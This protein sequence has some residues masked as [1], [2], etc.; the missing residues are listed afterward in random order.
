MRILLVSPIFPPQPTVGAARTHSFAREWTRLGHEV[1]VLTTAKQS[2]QQG[3]PLPGEGFEVVAIDYPVPAPLARLR[4]RTREEPATA[5]RGR[6][7]NT[8]ARLRRFS[9][10]YGALRAPDLTHHWVRPAIDWA[11]R[12]GPWEVVCSSF[13]PY[14]AHLAALE[15][16]DVTKAWIAD[17]RDPWTDHWLARGLY[18]I[19]RI[20]RRWEQQVLDGAD[21]LVTTTTEFANRLAARTTTPVEVVYNGFDEEA[22]STLDPTPAWPHD[23]GVTRLVYTGSLYPGWHD[24]DPLF[25]ALYHAG[26]TKVR[27]IVAG[28]AAPSWRA[29]AER[30]GCAHLLEHHGTVV[31][32]EARRMQRDASALL[33]L[34]G[35]KRHGGALPAKVLEYLPSP[36]P[37]LAF[38]A[39]EAS[40]TQRL[41]SDTG[42]GITTPGD[43]PS[44]FLLLEQLLAGTLSL[45]TRD[46]SRIAFYG[47]RHQAR[48]LAAIVE[49]NLAS[50]RRLVS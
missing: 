4:Q 32:D 31:P 3:W 1:T 49:R 12:H 50:R 6:L 29:A 44:I 5:R 22:W 28:G 18:P 30:W 17:F 20:E 41:L 14:T 2:D 33:V 39:N 10:A 16:R 15:L 35:A 37:I 9:G 36:A 34:D 40:P 19:T 45:P 24:P 48:R 25:A 8:A 27:M 46:P 11:R 21:V 38:G 7:R 43:E 23:D 47:R 13:G 42:R 26:G